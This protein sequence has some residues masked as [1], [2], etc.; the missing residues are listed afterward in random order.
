MTGYNNSSA[1]HLGY[2]SRRVFARQDVAWGSGCSSET[3]CRESAFMRHLEERVP[4][5]EALPPELTLRN[6]GATSAAPFS[7]QAP[8]SEDQMFTVMKA[9]GKNDKVTPHGAR[10]VGM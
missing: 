10:D 4:A 7:S 2:C 5:R 3:A 8:S 6:N 9:A 1:T